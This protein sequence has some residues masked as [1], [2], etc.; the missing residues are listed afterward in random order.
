MDKLVDY[1]KWMGEL[2]FKQYPFRH[3]DALVLCVISYFDLGPIFGLEAELGERNIRSPKGCSAKLK[4]CVPLIEDGEMDIMITGGD[5]GNAELLEAAARSRRFGELSIRNYV[6]VIDKAQDLQFAALC[7]SDAED[8]FIAEML[9]RMPS[10]AKG[11]PGFHH[12]AELGSV[13]PERG[14]LEI[15]VVFILNDS[16]HDLCEGQ[17]GHQ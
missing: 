16:R 10:A 4:D 13:I 8:G 6:D 14:V 17:D 5:M 15:Q 9:L 11:I 3:A 1:I 12:N 7:F 2:D